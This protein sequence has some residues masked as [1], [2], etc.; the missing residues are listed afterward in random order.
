[1]KQ[2]SYHRVCKIFIVMLHLSVAPA[3]L[4][5]ASVPLSS[6]EYVFH[7][8]SKEEGSRA[9][10]DES[11]EPYFSVLGALE[12]AALTSSP[13]QPIGSEKELDTLRHRTRQKMQA[14][15]GEF[16]EEEA[17][18]LGLLTARIDELVGGDFPLI[19]SQP[20]KL[21]K[22]NSKCC[23]T[24]H[25]RSDSII[26]ARHGIEEMMQLWQESGDIDKVLAGRGSLLLHE[27]MHIVQR[28][29]PEVFASL[30]NQL[31]GFVHVAEVRENLWLEM[32][33]LHNPDAYDLGYLLA[34]DIGAGSTEP[35][36]VYQLRTLL[37]PADSTR[38]KM[39][40]DFKSVAIEVG[41]DASGWHS[42]LDGSGNTIYTG[43]NDF[44]IFSHPLEGRA[45]KAALARGGDHP[46]EILAYSFE[47]MLKHQ[48]LA[49]PVS[50]PREE[51]VIERISREAK[52]AFSKALRRDAAPL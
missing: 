40:R 28:Y 8:L 49:G 34:F 37:M 35:G 27:Q 10:V 13:V 5:A 36:K 15:I 21:L 39:G 50:D 23:A 9:F 17:H 41:K 51:E 48:Y 1:M 47:A 24:A 38:P 33:V 30:Y 29:H 18:L 32:H 19:A 16:S 14:R 43:F 46:H 20:W 26:L 42:K 52:E 4:E 6:N 3:S 12:I 25:T 2:H 22:L 45:P 11:V 44:E 31:W 7:A